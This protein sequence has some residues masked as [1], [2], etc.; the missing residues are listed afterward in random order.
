MADTTF[1]K[2]KAGGFRPPG[3]PDADPNSG[4]VDPTTGQEQSTVSPP[5]APPPPAPAAPPPPPAAPA[6]PSGPVPSPG[7]GWVSLPGGGWA[8]PGHPD[9]LQTGTGQNTAVPGSPQTIQD[10]YRQQL[11]GLLQGPTPEQAAANAVT[12]PQVAAFQTAQQRSPA[13]ARAQLAET[14]A[15]QGLA[16]SGAQTTASLGL[17]QQRGEAEGQ[18]AAQVAQKAME[19]R[20]TQLMQAIQMAQQAGQFDAA[21]ALQKELAQMQISASQQDNAAELALREKLGMGQL[22]LSKLSL[23]EQKRV[24]DLENAY[25]YSALGQ[26]GELTRSAQAIQSAGQGIQQQLGLGDLALRERLGLG[27]LD[28][29][30]LELQMQGEQAADLLG[31]NYSQLEQSANEAA[32][33]YL[34]G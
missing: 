3:H 9:T 34:L 19:D 23:A 18:F 22:D 28:L 15:Q 13:R 5:P 8:P 25:K 31:F 20:R 26:E 32:A 24:A 30:K 2:G 33:K 11:M 27:D 4:M 7:P 16:G 29:R 6:A 14:A 21:Q 1:V 10:V 12:S 17:E